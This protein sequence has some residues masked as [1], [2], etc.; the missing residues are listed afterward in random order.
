VVPTGIAVGVHYE[1]LKDGMGPDKFA[2]TS[3][4]RWASS[5]NGCGHRL[6][7]SDEG[8]PLHKAT[9]YLLTSVL[10][11]RSYANNDT[12]RA[13][14]WWPL[15]WVRPNRGGSACG[16]HAIDGSHTSSRILPLQ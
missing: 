9:A 12:S 10:S 8:T 6:I 3:R 16:R 15:L 7:K 13:I 11:R 14:S 1:W 2:G 4:G 5:G